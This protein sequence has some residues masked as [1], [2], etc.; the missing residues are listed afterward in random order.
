MIN[1]IYFLTTYVVIYFYGDT[2]A[3]FQVYTI[4]QYIALLHKY[5]LVFILVL[6]NLE[7]G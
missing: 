5:T 3:R 1:V 7:T 2:L 6:V 4:H